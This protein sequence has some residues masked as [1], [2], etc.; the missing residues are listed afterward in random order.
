MAAQF[1]LCSKSIIAFSDARQ[2]LFMNLPSVPPSAYVAALATL[3]IALLLVMT[4]RWHGRFSAD[5]LQGV[6]K[7]HTIPTPR[8]GGLAIVLGVLAGY[9]LGHPGQQSLLGVLLLA[10]LPAF[11]FGLAED[12][13]KRVGVMPRLLATMASGVLGWWLTGQSITSVDLPFLDPLLTVP[14]ISVVFTAFAVGGVANA[15]NIVDGFNGLAGGF[16]VIAFIGLAMIAWSAGDVDL[17]LAS[18]TLA[19][20]F[21]GFWLINWPWGKIFLGDGGSYFGGFALAWA[22]VLLVER[23]PSVTPFAALLVCVHPVTEVLF[24]IYRRR[25]H[26]SHPGQP[27]RLHLHSLLMRR[28]VRPALIR[29]WSGD[30]AVVRSTQNSITGVLL[31]LMSV[32]PVL[33][34]A[35]WSKQPLLAAATVLLVMLGYVALYARLVR[36]HWCSPVKFVFVKPARAAV[37]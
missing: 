35:V 12:V 3:S 22:S 36:F 27:D 21:V 18:L 34:A 33:L 23:N 9:G 13:T 30:M 25:M 4:R 15:V 29:L 1:V 7:M 37:G 14:L 11:L 8:I 10:G 19:G 2:D 31:A 6:Q 28:V 26:G 16:L 5:G 20:A 24:S 32:P 17:C